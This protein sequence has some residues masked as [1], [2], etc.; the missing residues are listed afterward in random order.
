MKVILTG[1]DKCS[2]SP[3]EDV[4]RKVFGGGMWPELRNL[5]QVSEYDL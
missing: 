4:L 3:E 2:I 5:Y 1:V